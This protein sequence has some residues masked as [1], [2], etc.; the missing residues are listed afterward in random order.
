[1]K[2]NIHFLS[3]LAQFLLE[4]EMLQTEVVEKIKPHIT[5]FFRKLWRL[6]DNVKKYCKAGQATDDMAHT[7]CTADN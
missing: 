7:H 3:Y 4:W 6:W 5:L 2:T 1:M